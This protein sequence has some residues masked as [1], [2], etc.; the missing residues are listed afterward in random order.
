MKLSL[1]D[2]PKKL[3][4]L[5]VLGSLITSI[6]FVF[7]W[8]RHHHYGLLS[9]LVLCGFALFAGGAV[10]SLKFTS[11]L[12]HGVEN[13]N[14]PESQIEQLR[15]HLKSPWY[16]ALSIVLFVAFVFFG[17]FFKRSGGDGW[18]CFLLLQTIS[19][20]RIAVRRPFPRTPSSPIIGWRDLSPI[21]SDQWGHR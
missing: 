1:S 10:L 21:H 15:K 18:V 13:Q 11:D 4:L 20:L 2:S 19:Q 9:P 16:T 6:V 7:P 5:S 8:T 17:F 12:R 14:W 3:A